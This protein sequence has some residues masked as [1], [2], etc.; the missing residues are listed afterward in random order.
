[1]LRHVVVFKYTLNATEAQIE[2]FTME[3]ARLQAKSPGILSLEYGVNSS[4]EGKNLGFTHV[5]IL[6][7]EN[8]AARDSYLPHP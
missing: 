8:E 7:F 4:L 6:T 5:Y 2:T 1:M 3:L